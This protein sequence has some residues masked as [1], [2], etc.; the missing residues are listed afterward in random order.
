MRTVESGT[1][2]GYDHRGQ[3]RTPVLIVQ[4]QSAVR[5]TS[6]IAATVVDTDNVSYIWSR[7]RE[8]ARVEEGYGSPDTLPSGGVGVGEGERSG[9]GRGRALRSAGAARR[10]HGARQAAAT[11]ALPAGWRLRSSPSRAPPRTR[12]AAA[13]P[14]NELISRILDCDEIYDRSRIYYR[15]DTRVISCARFDRR[16]IHH[17]NVLFTFFIALFNFLSIYLIRYMGKISIICN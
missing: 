3:R 11:R 17:E 2:D 7:G 12:L 1:H 9:G 4:K 16:Q 10:G 5:R 15:R 13:R 14:P 8:R 6:R